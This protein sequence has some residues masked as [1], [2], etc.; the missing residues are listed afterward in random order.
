MTT[1]EPRSLLALDMVVSLRPATADD[2]PKLEWYGQYQHFRNLFR[3]AFREQQTGRRLILLAIVN[4]FPIGQIFIQYHTRR[5]HA[6][7][8]RAY[9]YSFRVMEMFRGQGI[10]TWLLQEAEAIVSD[11]G[12][13]WATIAA[14]KENVAARRL[15]ERL[16][17]RIIGEDAG[18]WSYI[19]H[20]GRTCK[21]DEPC[22][23]LEKKLSPR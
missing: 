5:A 15:Y 11:R 23:L 20:R 4:D 2:L 16:G 6:R 3:R 9:F 21:V 17:Y 7:A 22:W 12:L 8:P 19:D 1:I 10:G 18:H 13:Q 14:A